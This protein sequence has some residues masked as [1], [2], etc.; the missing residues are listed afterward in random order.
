M[1]FLLTGR[2]ETASTRSLAT[3]A[4]KKADVAEHPKVFHHVGLLFNEPSA[5]ADCSLDSHP[6]T[7]R[8]DP[9]AARGSLTRAA[10]HLYFYHNYT[11]LSTE[12]NAFRHSGP[13][14]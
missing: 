10:I 13:L 1:G 11:T 7:S 4:Q 6:K 2:L 5:A 12:H 3:K 9:F 8:R 14:G